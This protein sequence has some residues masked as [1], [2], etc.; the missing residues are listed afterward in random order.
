MRRTNSRN[1]YVLCKG[2]CGKQVPHW[3][4]PLV[5]RHCATTRKSVKS[6]TTLG[7]VKS[8]MTPKTVKSTD[9]I[10]S[11]I[12]PFLYIHSDY[13][14]KVEYKGTKT[15]HCGCCSNPTSKHSEDVSFTM[16]LPAPVLFV[17]SENEMNRIIDSLIRYNNKSYGCCFSSFTEYDNATWKLVHKT[18]H[19]KLADWCKFSAE[20]I[21]L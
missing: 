11:M 2:H 21:F 19:M 10:F 1:S 14:V 7:S 20:I 16:Y 6:S 4:M 18:P 9:P 12:E 8:T 13:A 15:S 3:I 5:C 17:E